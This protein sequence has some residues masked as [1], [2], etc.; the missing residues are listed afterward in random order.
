MEK[1]PSQSHHVS[2]TWTVLPYKLHNTIYVQYC[3]KHQYGRIIDC[4][5]GRYTLLVIV[6]HTVGYCKLGYN[7]NI[8]QVI[9]FAILNINLLN[10]ANYSLTI[11]KLALTTAY[12]SNTLSQTMDNR[13]SIGI[14]LILHC[15]NACS[16]TTTKLSIMVPY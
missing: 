13:L 1:H 4:H 16:I 7:C 9:L 12:N 2:K 3:T 11:D 6:Y 10:I 14:V 5:L 8:Y 15:C